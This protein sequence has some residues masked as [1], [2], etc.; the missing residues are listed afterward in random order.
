MKVSSNGRYVTAGT[1]EGQV[2]CFNLMTGAVSAILRD[3]E[4]LEIRDIVFHPYK[5]MLFT[6]SDGKRRRWDGGKGEICFLLVS[7]NTH[8]YFPCSLD[9]TVKSYAQYVK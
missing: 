1:Y 5:K 8:I 4:A 6:S 7:L 3:H 2:Y 9:G